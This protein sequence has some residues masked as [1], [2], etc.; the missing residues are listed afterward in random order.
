M[1]LNSAAVD[2]VCVT[3]SEG[4]EATSEEKKDAKLEF[5]VLSALI[6]LAATFNNRGVHS[7][8]LKSIGGINADFYGRYRCQGPRSPSSSDPANKLTESSNSSISSDIKILNSIASLLVQDNEVVAC[9]VASTDTS[10]QF[11]AIANSKNDKDHTRYFEEETADIKLLLP[12]GT[13]FVGSYWDAISSDPWKL[14][15]E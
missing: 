6:A 8:L 9:T 13:T 10:L 3:A 1:L 7:K 11:T 15:L 5:R 14:L 2:A 12:R 4:Q